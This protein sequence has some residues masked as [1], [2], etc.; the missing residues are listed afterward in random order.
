MYR[1][2]T[3]TLCKVSIYLILIGIQSSFI[4]SLLA[5]YQ[6]EVELMAMEGIYLTDKIHYR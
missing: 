6:Q 1:M 5:D 3:R 4:Y 2:G